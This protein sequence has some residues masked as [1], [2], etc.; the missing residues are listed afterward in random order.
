VSISFITAIRP[1]EDED[2]VIAALANQGYTLAFRAFSCEELEKYLENI[3]SDQRLLV[4][5]SENFELTKFVNAHRNKT[6]LKFVTLSRT[7]MKSEALLLD[8]V[9]ETL[10]R[11]EE[12]QSSR[13]VFFK[14]TKWI[15]VTGS[16]GSP[17]ITTVALNVASEISAYRENVLIDADIR[18]QDIHIRLGARREGKT[19]LTPSLA[20]TGIISQEDR[21]LL[22]MRKD[23]CCIFDVGQMP[24]FNESLLVDR[25]L[26]TRSTLE[27]VLRSS[28][29]V[30]VAQPNNRSLVELEKFLD[31]AH[32]EL[33]EVQILLFVNKMSSSDRQ[34]SLYKSFK[35]RISNYPSFTAPRDHPLIDR[36]EGRFAV[37]SEVGARSSLRKAVQELSIYLNKS[38]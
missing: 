22:E 28:T 6:N 25:R 14:E 38:I 24:V 12:S 13:S 4:I 29:I 35:N 9:H 30:Y 26:E 33:R 27:I 11:S 18:H 8:I 37:L 19:I 7:V 31:F 36:A 16:S 2:R 1:Y 34:K 21:A 10:R 3:N 32:R 23:E 5:M 15:A 20:F 17:G